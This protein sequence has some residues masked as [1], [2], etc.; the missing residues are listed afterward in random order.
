M[1]IHPGKTPIMKTAITGSNGFLG[2]GL[3][4][5]L[6][7]HNHDLRLIDVNH[8]P[9]APGEK[10][11]LDISH[12][13]NCRAAV[14]GMEALVIAHMAPRNPDAYGDPEL[15]MDINVKGTAKL[16]HAA[17]EAGISRICLISSAGT[18][19]GHPAGTYYSRDLEM[20]SKDLYSLTKVLQENIANHYHRLFGLPVAALRISGIVDV[21]HGITKYGPKIP[22]LMEYLVDRH[23]IGEVVHR[24]LE[25]EDLSWEIFYVFGHSGADQLADVGYTRKRLNWKPQFGDKELLTLY[26]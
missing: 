20:R 5:V 2:R 8:S 1:R 14:R 4:E 12:L 9:E 26:R 19:K 6:Q 11:T 3:V 15:P 13:E 17:V 22:R 23:D 24:V 7:K 21:R 18:V 16:F 10:L 25:L